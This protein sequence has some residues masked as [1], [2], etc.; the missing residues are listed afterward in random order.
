MLAPL[1]AAALEASTLILEVYARDDVGGREKADGSPV[2][3]ADGLAEAAILRRLAG[4]FPDV[5]VVAEEAVAAGRVPALG[6]DFFLVDPLDGT[7]EFLNRNGDFTVNIGRVR[8]GRPVTGVILAPVHGFVFAGVTGHGAWRAEVTGDELGPWRDVEASPPQQ[9]LRVV[10]SRSHLT[11]ATQALIDGLPEAA[12][13]R[14]GSSLKF[15]R[16]AAGEAD[17][18]PCLGP[19]SQWDTAAGEAILTAAGGRVLRLD[20]H[21]L[22]YGQTP[23]GFGNPAFVASGAFDPTPLLPR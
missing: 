22:F 9:P 1:V 3:E 16:L 12:L 13:T 11:P 2:T 6:D 14:A 10:A 19:T 8:R 7:R 23:Q 5:P 20:G 21:P 15:C 17:F 4:A 18:Y